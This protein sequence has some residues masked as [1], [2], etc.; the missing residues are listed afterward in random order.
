ML[1]PAYCH[2]I[3]IEKQNLYRVFIF[4]NAFL[5]LLEAHNYAAASRLAAD[6]STLVDMLS[7]VAKKVLDVTCQSQS[8]GSDDRRAQRKN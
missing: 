8:E 7:F 2:Y 6:P 5:G 1:H 3:G 4:Q